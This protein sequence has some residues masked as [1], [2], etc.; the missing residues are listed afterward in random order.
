MGL[1]RRSRSSTRQ[2]S[3]N[4]TKEEVID[5]DEGSDQIHD[6]AQD[7]KHDVW[8]EQV[9][10]KSPSVTRHQGCATT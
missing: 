10:K 6:T 3:G 5:V 2:R 7:E 9:E 1:N 4:G 8:K